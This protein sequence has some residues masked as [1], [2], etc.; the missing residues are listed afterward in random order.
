VHGDPVF[1]AQP[2]ATL[3]LDTDFTIRA[4]NKAYLAATG[5]AEDELLN[6]PL[7]EAFPDNPQDPAADG[8]ANL[9]R[10]LERVARSGRAH[11]MWAQRYDILD[12]AEGEWLK[13]YW[14]PVNSPVLDDGRVIG[15]LHRVEDLTPIQDG[16]RRVIEQYGEIMNAQPLSDAHARRFAEAARA[17]AASATE[18]QALMDEV[19]H[20]R[21]ALTSRATIDQAKGIIMAER[22]CVPEEA[23]KILASLSQDTHV[24]LADVAA[25]LVYKAQGPGT[26]A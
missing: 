15:V 24:R 4:A 19:M 23:F 16:L 3:L 12:V 21:R 8:V 2:N 6:I 5:R 20:L 18:H 25:A 11:N 7:F 14:G 1:D 26:A 22:R 10:S 9:S 17:F 13:R